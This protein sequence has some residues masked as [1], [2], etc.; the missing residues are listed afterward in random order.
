VQDLGNQL[1]QFRLRLFQGGRPRGSRPV[2]FPLL[3]GHHCRVRGQVTCL[4]QLMK[5]RIK[6]PGADVVTVAPKL[7]LYFYMISVGGLGHADGHIN[8]ILNSSVSPA[9]PVS[10][11]LCSVTYNSKEK[12]YS[13]TVML[14]NIT[15][16]ALTG[17]LSLGLTGLPGGVVLTDGTGTTNGSP[18]FR[19]RSSQF[20]VAI[21]VPTRTRGGCG[22]SVCGSA[23]GAEP[24]VATWAR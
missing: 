20:A 4:F 13:E 6:G 24:R 7:L 19:S 8:V 21:F 2:V 14:T 10:M 12:L 11:S 16:G 18:Y 22:F 1:S 3:A 15:N 5:H 9:G 17:P 23:S